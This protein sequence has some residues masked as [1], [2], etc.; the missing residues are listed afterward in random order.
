MAAKERP[1]IGDSREGQPATRPRSQSVIGRIVVV[2]VDS[3]EN[4]KYAFDY[5]LDNIH[6]SDDLV[7]LVHCPETPRLPSF[8][9][10]TGIAPPVDDW[11]KALDEMNSKTRQIEEDY[12]GTLVAKK[13]KYKVRGE[14]YK[15]PG[16]GI[17]NI[18]DEERAD[19]IVVGS[20][21]S[22][23]KRKLFIGSVSE[24]IVRRSNAATLVV[25]SPKRRMSCT[26][27]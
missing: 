7:V 18:A 26:D 17:L 2:A 6:K 15:N 21:G 19:L 24:Y 8:K 3:S 20:R 27:K 10:K 12:E 9:F 22:D 23:A 16:E 5:Y 25:P 4:A 13:L 14:S 11:K 1:S